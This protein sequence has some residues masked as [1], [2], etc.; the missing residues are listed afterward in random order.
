MGTAVAAVA[1]VAD[2]P[3]R[4]RAAMV[5]DWPVMVVDWPVMVVDWPGM[6]MAAMVVPVVS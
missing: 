6:V 2:W 1:A 3:A 4:M 5:A